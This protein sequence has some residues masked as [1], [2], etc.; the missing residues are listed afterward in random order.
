LINLKID[1][2]YIPNIN[3][4]KDISFFDDE[5]TNNTEFE[6]FRVLKELNKNDQKNFINFSYSNE[7]KLDLSIN[8][9]ENEDDWSII[10]K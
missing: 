9:V 8:N 1:P 10:N 6:T 2:Q 3:N 7:N 5:F 4:E